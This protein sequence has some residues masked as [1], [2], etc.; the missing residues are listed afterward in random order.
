MRC[1]NCKAYIPYDSKKS[2]CPACGIKIKRKPFLEDLINMTA[3]SAAD[4][5]FLFWSF[6]SLIAWVIAGA[7]EFGTGGGALFEYFEDNIFHS[8]ILFVFWGIVIEQIAKINAQIRL[9]SKTVILKERRN[10]RIFRM[11]SNLSLIAGIALRKYLGFQRI[12]VVLQH[13]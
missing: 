13:K 7:V 3:E 10:L 12:Y 4:R 1:N 2:E 5:N 6:F 9:A 8:L 11:G